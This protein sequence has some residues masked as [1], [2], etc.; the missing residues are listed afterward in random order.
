M[1]SEIAF[2]D[3]CVPIEDFV[4]KWIRQVNGDKSG[5][6][7]S[8]IKANFEVSKVNERV[9]KTI[10]G[11]EADGTRKFIVSPAAWQGK[12]EPAK[13]SV[14]VQKSRFPS[15]YYFFFLIFILTKSPKLD[16]VADFFALFR[17]KKKIQGWYFNSLVWII[18]DEIF[19]AKRFKHLI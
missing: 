19:I 1:V 14:S 9:L 18:R 16:L 2:L 12:F 8:E 11:A 7:E 17:H 6:D 4:V 10:C 5:G 3:S 15:F 13:T